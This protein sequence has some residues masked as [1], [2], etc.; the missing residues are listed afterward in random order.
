MEVIKT[1]LED[2]EHKKLY[3]IEEIRRKELKHNFP[4]ID[5]EKITWKL[6]TFENISKKFFSIFPKFVGMNFSNM[7]IAGGCICDLIMN[8]ENVIHD[9]DIFIYG[10]SSELAEKKVY[11]IINW[12][13]QFNKTIYCIFKENYVCFTTTT[14]KQINDEYITLK[15]VKIQIIFKLYNSILDILYSFDI[16]AS[17]I[18]F[19]GKDI[20]LS[21]LGLFAYENGYNIVS[22]RH[23]NLSMKYRYLKYLQK[24]FGIILPNLNINSNTN[25]F[26][27]PNFIDVSRIN[28]LLKMNIYNVENVFKYDYFTEFESVNQS[29]RRNIYRLIRGKKLYYYLDYKEFPTMTSLNKKYFIKELSKVIY[30][31]PPKMGNYDKHLEKI[32]NDMILL[33]EKNILSLYDEIKE[34]NSLQF[35]LE[36]SVQDNNG[37]FICSENVVNEYISLINSKILDLFEDTNN[38]L[39]MIKIYFVKIFNKIY[40]LKWENIKKIEEILN[41]TNQKE[42]IIQL[43]RN[44]ISLEPSIIWK[45]NDEPFRPVPF[46]PEELYGEFFKQLTDH[47]E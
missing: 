21:P 10:L 2:E 38:I 15:D 9:I 33:N 41:I 29:V 45:T 20:Y 19:D 13:C 26:H 40:E 37:N 42:K 18:G 22:I 31:F 24:G 17:S 44:Y 35:F 14:I 8:R 16:G 36:N 47:I 3:R 4:Y 7:L 12:F 23:E 6:C 25:Y 1:L 28:N 11:E 5:S 32:S 39:K 30:F 27:L 46:Q 34:F 43:Y